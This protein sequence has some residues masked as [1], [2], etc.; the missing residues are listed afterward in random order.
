MFFIFA[1]AGYF[2][3]ILI[4]TPPTQQASKPT[5]EHV[6]TKEYGFIPRQLNNFKCV[7][8]FLTRPT[9]SNQTL[10]YQIY[11]Y[12]DDVNAFVS[13]AVEERKFN[14]TYLNE[15]NG[16]LKMGIRVHKNIVYFRVSYLY[17]KA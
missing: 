15:K 9:S 14:D 6:F 3:L 16:I 2:V 4:D 7:F 17:S 1:K 12:I 10:H 5:V 11:W 13:D 8:P